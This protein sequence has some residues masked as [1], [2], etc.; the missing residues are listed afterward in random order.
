MFKQKYYDKVNKLFDFNKTQVL[1]IRCTDDNFNTVFNDEQLINKIK[2]INLPKNTIIIS[3]NYSIKV[4]MNKMFGFQFIDKP[5]IH[6]ANSKILAD[7]LESTII[8]Y[9]ILSKSSHN[10]CISYYN[11]GSGFSEQCSILNNIPYTLYIINQSNI[12]N[13][14]NLIPKKQFINKLPSNNKVNTKYLYIKN[15]NKMRMLI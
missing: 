15:S 13:S 11:H 10:Y 4:R 6:V 12:A 14:N 2:S 3:N 1:H 5:T 9:I 8:E 7:E